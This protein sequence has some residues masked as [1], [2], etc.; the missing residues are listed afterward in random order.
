MQNG[1]QLPALLTPQS[2]ISSFEKTVSRIR[3]T[4]GVSS[5]P[6]H[7]RQ[8][9]QQPPPR[10][11]P[12]SD[13]LIFV[14]GSLRPDIGNAM[15][16]RLQEESTIL[17]P[18]TIK[19]H[20]FKLGWYPGIRFVEN[21]DDW[22]SGYLLNLNN[23]ESLKWLDEYEGFLPDSPKES[24]FLRKKTQVSWGGKLTFAWCYEYNLEPKPGSRVISGDW[25]LEV[26]P[27]HDLPD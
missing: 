22:V 4:A 18:A 8:P 2:K 24:L 3:Q 6:E 19:A 21:T 9:T 23:A 12:L 20:L 11:T 17:G 25:K 26:A 27:D 14:Y 16:K 7:I 1:W 10:M 5:P 15:S 13:T